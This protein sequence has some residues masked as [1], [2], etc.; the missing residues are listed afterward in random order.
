[1]MHRTI[2][3]SLLGT[4]IT[5]GLLASGG[6]PADAADT[7]TATDGLLAVTRAAAPVNVP[8]EPGPTP[9]IV[10]QPVANPAAATTQ[11]VARAGSE[12]PAAQPSA[13]I[14]A[15]NAG[16]NNGLLVVGVLLLAFGG[17]LALILG[18]KRS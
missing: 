10:T 9:P 3:G 2:R 17:L 14:T 1:M 12:L 4:V 6:V 18:R 8:F 7:A 16:V 5:A 11:V 15:V 13:V